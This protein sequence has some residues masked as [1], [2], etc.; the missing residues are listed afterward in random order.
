MG[1]KGTFNGHSFANGNGGGAVPKALRDSGWLAG[2]Q[3]ETSWT[4]TL[5]MIPA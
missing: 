3:G 5:G 1:S 2:V 4:L